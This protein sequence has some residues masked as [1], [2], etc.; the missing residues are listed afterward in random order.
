[1]SRWIV[2]PLSAL[3]LVLA[4]APPATAQNHCFSTGPGQARVNLPA[5]SASSLSVAA[6]GQ[7]VLHM[8]SGDDTCEGATRD[9]TQTVTVTV[10][11][12][13]ANETFA[14]DHKGPGG[15]LSQQL[16][17]DLGQGDNTLAIQGT[18]GG[19]HVVATSEQI[20]GTDE[21]QTRFDMEMYRADLQRR[22]ASELNLDSGGDLV[23][24]LFGGLDLFGV[25]GIKA[26]GLPTRSVRTTAGPLVLPVVVQGGSG[27]DK[28]TG[29]TGDDALLGGGG[30]DRLV[31]GK[32]RD[33]LKGGP[34]DDTCKGGPGR[35]TEKGCE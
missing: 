8:A 22:E 29:G 19:D 16:S 24:L 27:N 12:G 6:D 2:P 25:A 9:S 4:G 7:L 5:G 34:G 15:A 11:G 17:V 13:D 20:P 28:L 35:D 31:G 14:V 21:I 30:K 32:G 10:T 18:T 23:V 33:L 1:M 3:T 26:P